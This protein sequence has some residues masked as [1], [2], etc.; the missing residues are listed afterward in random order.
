VLAEGACSNL[1]NLDET[2]LFANYGKFTP[3]NISYFT[4]HG[5]SNDGRNRPDVYAP[6]DGE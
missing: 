2:V 6:G 5:P 3:D 4:S 1:D